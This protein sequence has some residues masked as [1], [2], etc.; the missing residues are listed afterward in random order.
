MLNKS[1]P[2]LDTKEFPKDEGDVAILFEIG[3]GSI[4]NLPINKPH[5]DYDSPPPLPNYM[6][7]IREGS[8]SSHLRVLIARGAFQ[9]Y[10]MLGQSATYLKCGQLVHPILPKMRLWRVLFNRFILPQPNPGKYW[11]LELNDA[12]SIS[13]MAQLETILY[14]SCTYHRVYTSPEISPDITARKIEPGPCSEKDDYCS[15]LRPQLLGAEKINPLEDSHNRISFDAEL[16]SDVLPRPG[17]HLPS[18]LDDYCVCSYNST[19]EILEPNSLSDVE[20]STQIDEKCKAFSVANKEEELSDH[21]SIGESWQNKHQNE[22]EDTM[23]SISSFSTI[24]FQTDFDDGTNSTKVE[25]LDS[26]FSTERLFQ[27]EKESFQDVIAEDKHDMAS[28]FEIPATLK[29]HSEWK[30]GHTP[31]KPFITQ[32][33][34]WSL[35]SF[36][37]F[38]IPDP[39]YM[40]KRIRSTSTSAYTYSKQKYRTASKFYEQNKRKPEILANG[41]ESSFLAT[42]LPQNNRLL[43]PPQF[44]KNILRARKSMSDL[45]LEAILPRLN[46]VKSTIELHSSPQEP[47]ALSETTAL[48]LSSAT[49]DMSVINL[50]KA[51]SELLLRNEDSL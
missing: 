42:A 28:L 3:I 25:H 5:K 38:D 21:F 4:Y 20:E 10:R 36:K 13:E 1:K 22:D 19:D 47:P 37:R 39:L 49:S 24:D 43:V 26:G 16:I 32:S 8:H 11:L 14:A 40:R 2:S 31:S 9:I 46:P 33:T 48:H 7:D 45:V 34:Q 50:T 15:M 41:T 29:Q 27:D 18:F 30:P 6:L 17:A 51:V 44:H 12:C 23:F 35:P